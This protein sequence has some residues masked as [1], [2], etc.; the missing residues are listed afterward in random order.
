MMV[1][2]CTIHILLFTD[3]IPTTSM[4]YEMGWSMIGLFGLLVI[5]NFYHI[6]QVIFKVIKLLTIYW[7][8][9]LERHLHQSR[10]KEDEKVMTPEELAEADRRRVIGLRLLHEAAMK[11]RMNEFVSDKLDVFD[12]D[13]EA[14]ET[15][16]VNIMDMK[17]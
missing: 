10:N 8:R 3:Y 17:L 7:Y 4:Q 13:N 11:N 16:P 14:I 9:Y 12:T 2:F 6:F 5:F 15:D 1:A